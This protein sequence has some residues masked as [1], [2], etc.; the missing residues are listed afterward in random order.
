MKLNFQKELSS[1]INQTQKAKTTATYRAVNRSISKTNSQLKRELTKKLKLKS[2][3]VGKRLWTTKAT[4]SKPLG[5]GIGVGV[6]YGLPLRLFKPK[7]KT[8]KVGRGKKARRYQGVTIMSPEGRMLVEGGFLITKNNKQF[9]V[10]RKGEDRN[11][12]TE[13]K[14]NLKPYAEELKPKMISFLADEFK[15]QFDKQIGYELKK[16]K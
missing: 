11:P 10:K 1:I 8:V 4:P 2:S 12:L 13:P 9:V 16:I 6:H 15:V 3:D 5:G 14:I 7:S